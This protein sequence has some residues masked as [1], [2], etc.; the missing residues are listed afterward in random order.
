MGDDGVRQIVDVARSLAVLV[1]TSGPDPR[2]RKMHGH[3]FY[4]AESGKT[5]LSSSGFLVPE[6]LSHHCPVVERLIGHGGKSPIMSALV[7]TAASVVEPFVSTV[8]QDRGIQSQGPPQLVPGSQ[9]DVL[10]EARRKAPDKNGG[11]EHEDPSWLPAELLTLVDVPASSIALTSLL[12]G[13]GGSWESGWSLA[14]SKNVPYSNINSLQDEER[15]TH[16]LQQIQS[17]RDADSLKEPSIL[18][19]TTT[20]LAFLIL[21]GMDTKD[22]PHV[23][24]SLSNKRGDVLLAM[25]SPFGILSPLHFFNSVSVGVV[26]NCCPS[27]AS[28]SSLLMADIRCLPGMEGG[29]VFGKNACL[30]GILIR[31]MK[32]S[33]GGAEIQLVVPW[34]AIADGIHRKLQKKLAGAQLESSSNTVSSSGLRVDITS[35]SIEA[36]EDAFVT[37]H[38]SLFQLQKAMAS[39]VLVTVGDGAWASGIILNSKGL[40]LTNAHLLEP[41]RFR[42]MLQVSGI[43]NKLWT[44]PIL[45]QTEEPSDTWRENLMPEPVLMDDSGVDGMAYARNPTYQGYGRIRVRLDHDNTK[46][47]CD[48]RTVYV[49]R[50][51]LDI[52]LLQ[53]DSVPNCICP[54]TPEVAWPE[55]GSKAF[56]IGH[57]LFGPRSNLCPS[58]SSGVIAR[59]VKTSH[60]AL[61]TG[62]GKPVPAMLETT[63][64]VH[65]GGSGGGVFNS[66]GHLIGLVT[67]NAR[68]SRGTI[69]PHLNFSIPLA[70]LEPVFRFSSDMQDMS[71]L[72]TL[73]RSNEFA[74]IWS[75][76]PPPNAR[77]SLPESIL[78]KQDGQKGSRFAKFIKEHHAEKLL[79]RSSNGQG[80]IN[81]ASHNFRHSKM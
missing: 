12:K 49:S 41:W 6:S 8:H 78:D 4:H 37:I 76:V 1:R 10:I 18:A 70:P 33:A 9:I 71:I 31:P 2:G 56:V 57:G 29:P 65:P 55:P 48:A 42:E 32:Q 60:K 67:S 81:D 53:I 34:D 52:A 64:A 14:S 35:D 68:H 80:H 5:T 11:M 59:V 61:E 66:R 54:V 40:I 16:Y 25:G 19:S 50:G 15:G 3:A 22:R 28:C 46:V 23:N 38:P 74:A 72:Q 51:S 20:R 13:H 45:S 43:A 77:P 21:A 26:A 63:A 36:S 58:V 79:Q 17:T 69:I 7:V 75:L 24:I 44:S 30:V 62:G 39:V 27:V 73:E 47:W